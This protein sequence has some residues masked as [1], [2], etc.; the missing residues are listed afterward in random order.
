MKKIVFF[1][2]GGLLCFLLS[3]NEDKDDTTQTSKPPMSARVVYDAIETGDVS[4]L[5]SF[6]AKD[7]VDH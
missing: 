3:C 4:K 1:A 2:A 7:I 6:L 5:D